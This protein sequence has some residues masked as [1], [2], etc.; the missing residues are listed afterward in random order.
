M[1]ANFWDSPSA[2][3]SL[4]IKDETLLP[5]KS[6]S[7]YRSKLPARTRTGSAGAS[8]HSERK[9]SCPVPGNSKKPISLQLP[10]PM[11]L[12]RP[13][14][15]GYFICSASYAR[16]LFDVTVATRTEVGT[17]GAGV[18]V[19]LP[20]NLHGFS[21]RKEEERSNYSTRRERKG[22]KVR[23]AVVSV[24]EKKKGKC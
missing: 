10:L 18:A 12:N 9:S 3:P 4:N 22:K 24:E 2:P 17:M 14:S 23:H 20:V 15:H 7:R 1:A 21:V 11:P 16:H 5:Q 8:F 13:C 19:H 6:L